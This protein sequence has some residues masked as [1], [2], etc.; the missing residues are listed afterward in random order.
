MSLAIL[1]LIDSACFRHYYVY[2]REFATLLLGYHIGL[3]VLGLLCVG[4]WVWF[5]LSSAR[6]IGFSLQ[7]HDDR[8]NNV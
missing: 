5:G 1:F 7:I 8:H 6:V 3:I 2:H 4:G